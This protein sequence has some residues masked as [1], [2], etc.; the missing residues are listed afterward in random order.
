VVYRAGLTGYAL[1]PRGRKCDYLLTGF[2]AG[3]AGWD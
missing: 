3:G 1:L 2:R